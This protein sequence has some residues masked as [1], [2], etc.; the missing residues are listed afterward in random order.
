MKNEIN[1]LIFNY[2]AYTRQEQERVREQLAN[3]T[4]EERLKNMSLEA[5]GANLEELKKQAAE[6]EKAKKFADKHPSRKPLSDEEQKR[7]DLN[8]RKAAWAAKQ[9]K[10]KRTPEARPDN[11]L[12]QYK[13]AKKIFYYDYLLA[14]FKPKMFIPKFVVN[15]GNKHIIAE[16]LKW[17]IR[18]TS[19]KLDL[20]K[21]LAFLG[22]VGTG[23]T[24]LMQQ[25][26]QFAH[27]YNLP[28][29]AR[30]ADFP[31]IINEITERKELSVLTPY[32]RGQW[33]FDDIKPS[34]TVNEY[35][36]QVNVFSSLVESLYTRWEKNRKTTNFT[37]NA[38][39]D[40]LRV[41]ERAYDRVKDMFNVLIFKG[42][43]FRR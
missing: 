28:S 12:M 14:N 37:A 10:P 26:N 33:V 18:D 30:P 31:K 22:G 1:D 13:E 15:A 41:E 7:V 36:N 2:E 38:M 4:P 24:Y 32:R 25:L 19:C 29:A 27:D 3:E 21:G 9:P 23:K 20:D 6:N 16:A 43:N 11:N 42:D 40:D 17:V 39:P 8:L 35:G 5:R 34:V